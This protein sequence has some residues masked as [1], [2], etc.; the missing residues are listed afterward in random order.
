MD[1]SKIAIVSV[2]VLALL[3]G[4]IVLATRDSNKDDNKQSTTSSQSS[5]STPQQKEEAKNIVEIASSDT[6]FST[7]VAAVKAAG[8]VDTLS[9]DG[10]FTVFAPTNDA[11]NKLPA[12]TLDSLLKPENVEQL[13]SILTYH[14]I[15]AKAMSGDL[16]DGQEITTVQ[17][18]KLKVSIANG[19]VMLTDAKGNMSKVTKADIEAKN[20]VIHV[21]DMVVLPQ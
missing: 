20:G 12:G 7:L 1:K 14:V 18:A 2:L 3:G 6:Q 4:G 17:G 16:K 15:P 13:K 9:G 19:E 5:T 21:I 10:P 11:F 8:L